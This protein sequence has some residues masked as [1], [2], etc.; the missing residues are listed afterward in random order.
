VQYVLAGATAAGT[1][2]GNG[3]VEVDYGF[4]SGVGVASGYDL[5][6]SGASASATTVSG[7]SE[8]VLAGGSATGTTVSNGLEVAYGV[9]TSVLIGSGA[10]EFVSSGGTASATT[11]SGGTSYVIAGGTALA[12]KLVAGEENVFGTAI[13]AAISAV[14]GSGTQVVE[15]G[16]VTSATLLS[17][18]IVD[19]FAGGL[20]SG[21]TIRGGLE[22]VFAGGTASGTILSGGE[23]EVASGAVVSGSGAVTFSSG[24]ILRLDDSVHFGGLVAGF[25]APE[26]M[27]LADIPFVSS[28]GSGGATTVTWNQTTSGASGSGSLVV[29][30]GTHSA[31]LTL[32]GNYVQGNFNIQSDGAGGTFVTDPPVA[33]TDPGPFALVPPHQ[34]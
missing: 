28:G 1:V 18:G 34:T 15:A 8:Y 30:Q 20:A 11:I 33:P 27:D 6:A 2:V 31:N 9:V 22:Y 26:V 4:I 24:G 32:L 10:S 3:G 17:G 21:T 19:V 23:F 14:I 7:G 25:G 12:P 5:V 29:A 16:G 13:S